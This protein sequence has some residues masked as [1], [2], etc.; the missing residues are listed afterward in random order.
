MASVHRGSRTYTVIGLVIFVQSA[1]YSSH[2]H[3]EASLW[4]SG[5]FTLVNNSVLRTEADTTHE[6]YAEFIL[7]MK[8][9]LCVLISANVRVIAKAGLKLANVSYRESCF[10]VTE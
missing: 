10:H 4:L 5:Q 8:R 3:Y 6:K 9:S 7:K 1:N 2:F